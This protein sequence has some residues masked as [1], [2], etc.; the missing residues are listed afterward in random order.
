MTSVM[1]WIILPSGCISHTK[2]R[3][4]ILLPGFMLLSLSFACSGNQNTRQDEHKPLHTPMVTGV[5]KQQVNITVSAAADLIYAFRE[6]G[7]LFE[8]KTGTK[9]NFNFGSTGQL[10]QQIERGA[11][12]DVFAAANISFVDYLER[13]GLMVPDTKTIYARGFIVIWSRKDSPLRFEKMEDLLHTGVRRI[14]ISNPDHAPYGIAARES[15]QA[16]GIWEQVQPKLVLGENARQTFQYAETGNV[17]VAII[18]LSLAL[19][20]EGGLYT[21]V[22]REM[23]KPIDQALAVIKGTKHEAEAIA[24]TEFIKGP[25]GR[26]IMRRYGFVLPGEQPLR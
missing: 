10:A 6:L 21:P 17:D 9:V 4:L 13:Q 23:H 7:K 22:A 26:L 12:V 1:Q 19:A 18:P 11:A 8:E 16:A 3:F 2:V 20:V 24:F 15:L 25:E 5:A 14:A